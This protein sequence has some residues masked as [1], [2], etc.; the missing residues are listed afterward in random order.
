MNDVNY[1]KARC[2]L[3]ESYLS[4]GDSEGYTELCEELRE[5]SDW[6]KFKELDLDKKDPKYLGIPNI[7]FS[8]T[9]VDDDREEG[10]SKQR[11]ERGFD[12]SELW[13]LYTG[14]A[15]FILPRLKEF[16]VFSADMNMCE[17]KP[18]QIQSAIAAFEIIVRDDIT[19]TEE[20]EIISKGLDDFSEVF[21]R[22]WL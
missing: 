4:T 22:L 16:A 2:E 21:F 15:E 7:S 3:A 19:T 9:S 12:N 8:L 1:W 17:E 6:K 13:S 11:V 14:I 5:F 10:Y 20:D 18:I